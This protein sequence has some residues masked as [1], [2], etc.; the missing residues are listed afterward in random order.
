MFM[1]IKNFIIAKKPETR[2]IR[3]NGKR[4]QVCHYSNGIAFCP[5]GEWYEINE[6]E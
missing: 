6:F 1:F 3:T 5:N 2:I 4:V